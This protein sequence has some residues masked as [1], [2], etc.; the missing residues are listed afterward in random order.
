MSRALSL[1]TALALG[2]IPT[3]GVQRTFVTA[4]QP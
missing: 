2:F 3:L 4:P 1:L